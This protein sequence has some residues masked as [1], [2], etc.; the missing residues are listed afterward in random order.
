MTYS[1]RKSKKIAKSVVE[2]TIEVYSRKDWKFRVEMTI[3]FK[4]ETTEQ[5][6]RRSL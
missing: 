1:E 2:T 5:N 6:S 4:I 3:K